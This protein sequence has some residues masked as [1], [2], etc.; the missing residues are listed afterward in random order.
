M[1]EALKASFADKNALYAAYMPYVKHGGLF[2][3]ISQPHNLGEHVQLQ[4]TLLDEKE[5]F[6][7]KGK[8]IWTT[9]PG[10]QGSRTP[11][12]GIQLEGE[13]GVLL[14]NKIET[15]LAGSLKSDRLTN[16]M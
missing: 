5:E 11:G 15:Y 9:P 1:N 3:P 6:P 13:E 4:V 12:F 10:A 8:V 16:T 14:R 2:I 7:I